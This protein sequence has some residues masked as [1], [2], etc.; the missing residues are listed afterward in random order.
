MHYDIKD[1][2]LA[3]KGAL[4]IEWAANN[5][6]VLGLIKKRFQKEKPL[7]GLKVS[8]CLHVTT[9]TAVLMEVLKAGGASLWLCAS[10]PLSTQDDVASSLAKDL[11]I[12]VYSIK[13]ED[14]KTYYRH[15]RAVLA[16]KPDVTM[17]DGADLVSSIH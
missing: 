8:A 7:K 9:E 3:K 1:I 16:I 6:P 17:D 2:K 13:G 14:T 5:M 11:K 15:I 12:A 4:R 10:N